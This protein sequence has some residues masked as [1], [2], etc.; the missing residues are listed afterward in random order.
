MVSLVLIAT[1]LAV[2]AAAVA[3]AFRRA[4][5][6]RGG[7]VVECGMRT[8][9]GNSWRLGLAA[10]RPGELCWY[11]A[12][13][14]RLRPDE[15]FDRRELWILRSR[16]AWPA[17]TASLGPG[18]LIV[19]CNAGPVPAATDGRVLSPAATPPRV[20]ELAMSQAALTGYLAWLEAAPP[21]YQQAG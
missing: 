17:E 20:V 3:L 14:F 6:G 5:I 13:G 7:G 4:L 2:L 21:S 15:A 1:L 9:A 8:G 16:P 12:F 11:R 18:M 10:Y 19:E